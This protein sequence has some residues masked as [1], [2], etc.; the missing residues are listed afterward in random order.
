MLAG[1]KP[2]DAKRMTVRDRRFWVNWY[3]ALAERRVMQDVTKP[4]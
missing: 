3:V 1:W 4:A 2:W